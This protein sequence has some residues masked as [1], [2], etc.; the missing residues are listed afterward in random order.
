MI[1]L[2]A[3]YF[4]QDGNWHEN[5]GFYT[6]EEIELFG[7]TWKVTV[8]KTGSMDNMYYAGYLDQSESIECAEAAVA[9]LGEP[10]KVIVDLNWKTWQDAQIALAESK[11]CSIGWE[12]KDCTIWISFYSQSTLIQF[13]K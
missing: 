10:T 6:M 9:E 13:R 8:N 5:K 7:N 12:L 1:D 3:L 11:I 2:D 4:M